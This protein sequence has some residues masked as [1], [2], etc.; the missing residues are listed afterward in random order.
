MWKK[1]ITAI[2]IVLCLLLAISPAVLADDQP[3]YATRGVV[4]DMLL[5]A[6]DDYTPGLTRGDIIKGYEDGQTKEDQ[7]I[8]RAESFVMVS[9][10][11]GT[12]PAPVGNDLRLSPSLVSFTQVPV[13]AEYDVNNLINARVIIGTDDGS[14]H[15]SDNV[16]VEQMETMIR[17]IWALKGNNIRDDFY[18]TANKPWLDTSVISPGMVTAGG[19]NDIGELNDKRLTQI[20][21][22]ITSSTY[23]KGTKEQKIS[24]F[25]HN[26]LDM[27]AR[28]KEGFAPIKSYLEKIDAVDSMEELYAVQ[29][30]LMDDLSIG[31][32][33]SF[34]LGVDLK[35][36]TQ[37]TMYFGSV[38]PGLT[39]DMYAGEDSP[40]VVAYKQYLEKILVL[41]G[42]DNPSDK[43]ESFYVL[44]KELS[45]SQ[46]EPQERSNVDKIYNLYTIDKIQ[47]MFTAIDVK[48]I[49]TDLG[50][51]L[52]DKIIV[53]DVGLMEA[54]A[55]YYTEDNLSLLKAATKISLVS[56]YG[57][58]FGQDFLD[59]SN[60]F[61]KV[62]YGME[63][64]KTNAEIA[65]ITTQNIMSDYLGKIFI[66][67]YF[68]AEAKRDVENMVNEF[69]DIYKDRISNLEWMSDATKQM[70]AKKLDTMTTKIGYPDSWE[71]PMDK[72]EIKSGEDG[73]SYFENLLA[74]MKQ[75]RLET[76]ALQGKPVDKSKWMMSAYTVNAY[77]NPPSNEIVFPA[78][79]LQAPFYDINAPKEANLGGIGMIIAHEITHA[80]DNNGSKFDEKGNA[81][82]WWT[83]SDLQKFEQ[84]CGNVIA[85]Y[86]KY[87]VAPGIYTNG[88]LTL[89]ENI[90]DLGGMAC[91]LESMKKINNADYDIF[92]K[93]NAKIW[94]MTCTRQYLE[95]ANQIDVHSA[96]KAR[97]NK[98]VQ[99]FEEF[100]QTYDITESDG[101]YISP[102]ERVKIW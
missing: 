13:W 4:C 41:V 100:Y 77:Y 9:R 89:S 76:I 25:Y 23:E 72:V 10:A 85:H 78:G 5:S 39:K 55:K 56:G 15:E 83:E 33:V 54:F 90:A 59:V 53:Q 26:V 31:G 66:D 27:D 69:V 43:V 32:L 67:K 38:T 16:T 62:F 44:E 86:D 22:D 91:A 14:L 81:T 34:S 42:D 73:G 71:T 21:N 50:F 29:K 95:Y 19:F 99:N 84:L 80:F 94:E 49:I 30:S 8:T 98:V 101:M 87:E 58:A 92:F 64:T 6:A 57:G 11:F 36:S 3:N 75:S 45:K 37:Y 12:L 17:R 65:S 46:I 40:Q 88:T 24:S 20:I 68:S 63:G 70:A 47:E 60:E 96:N 74:I 51:Q 93:N 102:Q 1:R 48:Q 7:F 82:D 18:N 61:N 2:V 35:D 28:N 79:I 97:V 52:P